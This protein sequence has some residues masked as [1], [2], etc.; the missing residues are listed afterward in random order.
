MKEKILN[1]LLGKEDYVSGQELCTKFGVSR[2]AIWKVMNQ[3]KEDGYEIEAVSHKGYRI[4]SYPDKITEA[5]VASRLKTA[6][7]GRTIE[8]LEHVDSTNSHAKKIAESGAASGT[9]VI[10]EDQYGGRGRRGRSWVNPPGTSIAMTLIVRPDLAPNKASMMTLVMGIA[11]AKACRKVTGVET[12]IKWPNDVIADGKKICG[13]LTEM[14]ADPD[15]IHYVVIGTGINVNI[16]TFSEEIQNVA[17]SLQILTGKKWHRADLIGSCMEEFEACY[18]KFMQT[19]DLSLLLEEYHS[20]LVNKDEKVSVLD[21]NGAY[22]GTALGIDKNGELIVKKDSGE[23]TLV[24]AG[25][26]SVRG[27]YGY[28]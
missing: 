9:L 11:V 10:T 19:E 14:S 23:T 6:W 15:M 16:C 13:I 20:L 3:L 24:Y 2:T 4:V 17:T 27:V 18:E 7:A 5:E 22:T 25:E 1:A 26:V 28:V 8:F 12:K 21:P